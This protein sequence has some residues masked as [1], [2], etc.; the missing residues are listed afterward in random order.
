MKLKN[1]SLFVILALLMAWLSTVFIAYCF[2]YVPLVPAMKW[3]VEAKTHTG[4]PICAKTYRMLG[5]DSPL[6][7]RVNGGSWNWFITSVFGNKTSVS[8]P[9][10][11]RTF[12]CLS[13]NSV[14]GVNYGVDI[15]DGKLDEKWW[16]HREGDSIVFSNAV[17]SVTVSKKDTP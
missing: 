2:G 8:V 9:N 14:G 13:V 16:L 11:L 4:V 17:I 12:P 3:R 1:T 10:H 5:R 7:L 6:F 15:L